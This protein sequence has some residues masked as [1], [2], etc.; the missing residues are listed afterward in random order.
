MKSD[1]S[2]YDK[3]AAR[4]EELPLI[5][6][7]GPSFISQVMV[8]IKTSIGMDYFLSFKVEALA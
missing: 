2:I 6:E 7:R 5:I 1:P 4:L 3:V 8:L